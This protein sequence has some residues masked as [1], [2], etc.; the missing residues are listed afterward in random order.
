M[1]EANPLQRGWVGADGNRGRRPYR[2]GQAMPQLPLSGKNWS[3]QERAGIGRLEAMCSETNHWSVDC[4]HTDLG[5]PWCIIYDQQLHRIVL[6]IAHI[7]RRYVVVWPG[8]SRSAE[9]PSM[10]AAVEMA[11][12]RLRGYAKA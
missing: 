7:D 12:E 5:D 1:K 3:E 4:D 9:T 11:M 6:H 2:F 8:E 10:T